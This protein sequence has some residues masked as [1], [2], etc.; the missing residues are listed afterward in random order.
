METLDALETRS[1]YQH[2]LLEQETGSPED[3]QIQSAL[4]FRRT[5][6]PKMDGF[7]LAAS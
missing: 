4:S 2:P 6:V 1:E 3:A 7:A 5:S